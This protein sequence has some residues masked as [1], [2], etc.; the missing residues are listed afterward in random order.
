MAILLITHDL[1]VV[2]RVADRVSVMYAGEIVEE[3][4]KG[5]VFSEARHPYTQG[6]LDCVPVP[7]RIMAGQ[8]L[9]FIPGQ[10]PSL[11]GKSLGCMFHNRC[12]YAMPECSRKT[13]NFS[14]GNHATHQYRCLLSDSATYVSERS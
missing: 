6:L 1:G 12:Q 14:L 4:E 10:V 7:G 11:I 2:A 5:V 13:V 3:G 9:G 8:R